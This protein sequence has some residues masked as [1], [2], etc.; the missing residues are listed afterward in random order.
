LF[1]ILRFIQEK[2]G[3]DATFDQDKAVLHLQKMLNEKQ[4]AF[5]YDLSAATDR[6]P[7]LLQIKLLN[8]VSPKLGDHWGNLLTN[9]DYIVPT[10]KGE[11]LPESVRYS[12][13]QPM[14]ALSS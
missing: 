9:R 3:T 12:T 10:R 5:S 4:V 6:L 14:G 1:K 8:Y 2:Y 7:L 13:G 11:T